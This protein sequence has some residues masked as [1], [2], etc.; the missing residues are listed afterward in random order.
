PTELNKLYRFRGEEYAGTFVIRQP[1]TFKDHKHYN[2]HRLLQA[3][4]KNI[5]L[6]RQDR[7]TL[8]AADERF[9]PRE[10]VLHHYREFPELLANTAFVMQS[11]GIDMDFSKPKTKAMFSDSKAQD[12]ELL[13]SLAFEGMT[14]RYDAHNATARARVE[15]ELE[16]IDRQG[17]NAYFLITWDIIRFARSKGFFYVGRGSG[18]NSMVAY[19]LNITDVDPLELDL[20]F[21]R[22][23]NPHRSSPPDFDIDFSWKDRDEVIQYVFDRHGK[24]RVCLLG[25]FSTFQRN[26]MIRELGKVL[27][28]PKGE[29]DNLAN[30]LYARYKDDTLQQLIKTYSAEIVNFPNHLSI[31]AGGILIS[32]APIHQYTAT[33]LPP[34]GFVTA[35]LDMHVADSIGLEKLDILSQRGLGHIKEAV[36]VI[37]QNRNISID[38]HDVKRFMHDDNVNKNIQVADTIGCFYIESPA[39]RQLLQKLRCGDYLTLVAASSIIRPGVAQSGM[40][41][42]YI[43]RYNNQDQVT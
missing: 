38:I 27:G 1:V 20:Y 41:R 18:A 33:E 22:F 40:M 24:D 8:A 13:R 31:H 30:N 39:M 34:K 11:C 25:M 15:K 7:S 6:S 29:I 26:A 28:L 5:L 16:V 14:R 4:D 23:L 12:K 9:L 36:E 17:F 10:Q 37:Q 3:V 21:E 35:Q 19:C 42:Q 32:E 2:I 43:Y